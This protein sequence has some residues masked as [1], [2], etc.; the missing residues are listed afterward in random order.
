KE[1]LAILDDLTPADTRDTTTRTPQESAAA[2]SEA[3]SSRL[4][5][6]ETSLAGSVQRMEEAV[7]IL[8]KMKGQIERIQQRLDKIDKPAPIEKPAP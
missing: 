7:D 6:L 3:L 4:E 8:V 5:N 1:L 2:P